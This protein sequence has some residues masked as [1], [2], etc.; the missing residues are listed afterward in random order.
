VARKK[1]ATH[2]TLVSNELLLEDEASGIEDLETQDLMIPRIAILQSGSPQLKKR[3]AQYVQDAE[4]GSI[5]NTVLRSAED[6]ERGITVVPLKY[7][8]AYIEW[9]PRS[10]GGGFIRDHGND[11]TILES[12]EQNKENFRHITADGNEIVTTAEY[13][14]FIVDE[15]GRHDPAVLS[16]AG[17]QLKKSR[18]WNSMLNQLRL[19]NPKNNGSYF[20]PAMF[21]SAFQLRTV[22]EEN[23]QGTWFGWDIERLYG[24]NGGILENLTNGEEIYMAARS[25]KERAT[26]GSVQIA[27]ETAVT[28]EPF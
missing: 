4:A 10:S 6:G 28:E 24:E 13:F 17:S 3:D 22:P 18:R 11:G 12:C 5:F 14:V 15:K 26:Q 16:M 2:L 9:K 21:Y 23:D 1:K 7:R 25:F 20:T 8:R 27:P 19:P